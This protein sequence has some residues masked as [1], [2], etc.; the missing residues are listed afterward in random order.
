M[1]RRMRDPSTDKANPAPLD[2]HTEKVSVLRPANRS[3]Y[4]CLALERSSVTL[5]SYTKSSEVLTILIRTIQCEGH[6]TRK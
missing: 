4:A 5:E 1:G 6:G 2:S 3:S